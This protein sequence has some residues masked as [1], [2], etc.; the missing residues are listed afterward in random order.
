MQTLFKSFFYL[1]ANLKLHVLTAQQLY[2]QI[3]ECEFDAFFG[4]RRYLALVTHYTKR[5]HI[6][7]L[8]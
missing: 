6:S 8:L 5:D 1:G 4:K 2:R 3:L 7:L